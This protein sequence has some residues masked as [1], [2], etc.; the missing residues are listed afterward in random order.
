MAQRMIHYLMGEFI[1]DNH[2]KDLNRFRVGNLLPD[3]YQGIENRSVTHFTKRLMADDEVVRYCD[4]EGFLALF[5]DLMVKDDL[6]L[7]YFL[8]LVEDA[9]FRVYFKGVV[10]EWGSVDREALHQ[11]YHLL[12]ETIVK[13]YG[14]INEIELLD[15]FDD[16]KINEV[17]P[18]K[19]S[20]FLEEFNQDFEEKFE[21]EAKYFTLEM[22]EKFLE[23]YIDIC[24]DAY[25]CIKE[26]TISDKLRLLKW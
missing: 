22:M 20:E 11:D 16:E 15:K 2:I 26:G 12:N 21:G 18:F 4:F 6:Y 24:K 1:K 5:G 13:K 14:L 19:V 3:A 7:G 8:H 10:K 9:C 17:Y 25:R 23:A